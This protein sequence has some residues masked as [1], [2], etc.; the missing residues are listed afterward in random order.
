MDEFTQKICSWLTDTPIM[1]KDQDAESLGGVHSGYQFKS[2]Q[3]LP[4]TTP[5]TADC[6]SLLID[7]YRRTQDERMR[8]GAESALGYLMRLRCT[9]E[10]SFAEHTLPDS[11]DATTFRKSARYCTADNATVLAALCNWQ[12][13]TKSDAYLDTAKKI[14]DWVLK[15]QNLDGSFKA[16]YD[17]GTKMFVK[18][19]G[20]TGDR[21]SIHIKAAIGLLKA[22]DLSGD[23]RY[24]TGA[25]KT[26][27]WGRGIQK[28]SGLV[29]SSAEADHALTHTMCDAVEAFL[30]AAHFLKDDKCRDAALL[31]A[32][33]LLEAQGADG[34]FN[35]IYRLRTTPIDTPYRTTDATAQAARI[36]S[37][38]Y[39]MTK[40]EPYRAA[41]KKAVD[42]LTT[43]QCI[44]TADRNML[45]ALFPSSDDLDDA[46]LT[47]PN[48][49]AV[50]AVCL[51][52]DTEKE[53]GLDH[54][55]KG[56]F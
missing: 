43:R 9:D 20:V 38:V 23:E 10:S 24:K 44:S 35:R 27:D 19:E 49:L 12:F 15:M 42:Y 47:R 50:S 45:N 55:V 32:E 1:N 30:F 56:L 11:M 40:Q 13:A 34:A 14:A 46:I 37:I 2:Q 6:A 33:W 4:L 41:A 22:F 52:D 29:P 8:A 18:M 7:R 51:Y 36:F 16:V 17:A 48:L 5:V 26:L 21:C 31:A 28:N 53:D 25:L 39:L 54:A 3:Y